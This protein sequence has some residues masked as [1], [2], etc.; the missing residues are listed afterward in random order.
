MALTPN[1][2]IKL[3]KLE[4]L[5]WDLAMQ[6]EKSET[7]M[8][9]LML[10]MQFQRVTYDIYILE[11]KAQGYTKKQADKEMLETWAKSGMPMPPGIKELTL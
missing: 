4:L 8:R 6:M 9:S 2:E 11:M 7:M 3:G 5:Q 1:Q 10:M